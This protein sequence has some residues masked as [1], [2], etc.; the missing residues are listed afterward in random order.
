MVNSLSQLEKNILDCKTAVETYN[1]SL[2][3][4]NWKI[5]ERV[6]TEFGNIDSE[7]GNLAD[8]FDNF[9]DI[10]V[11]DGEG[12]W[13]NQAIATLGLYAQ[14][15][16]LAKYQVGQ[17]GDAIEQ[18]KKDYQAG[19]YSATEYMDKLADLSQE[20]WDAIDSIESME[21]AIIS[22]NETRVNEEIEVINEAI[23]AYKEYTDSQIDA[24]E[25]A[26]DL[27]DYQEE[28]SNKTK[29]VSDIERQLAAMQND[30]SAATIA[31]RKKLEE[32][33]SEA[34]KDLEEAEYDHS[35]ESQKD[36]LN[37]NY[38]DFEE[39][40]NEEIEL[41]RESLENRE[42]LIS[43]SLESVKANANLVG[44]E[45]AN[46]ATQHG[47]IV[48]DAIISSWRTGENAIASYGAVLSQQSSAFIG[49][50]MGVQSYVYG[51]Q[52]QAND[53]ANSLSYMFST[54][55]DNL[56]NQLTSSYYSEANLNS[57]TNT[58]QNS[59]INTLERG[60][61]IDS[62]TNALSSIASGADSVADA[63]GRAARALS[64]MGAISDTGSF[65]DT[66]SSNR[67]VKQYKTIPMTQTGGS[68]SLVDVQTGRAIKTGLSFSEAKKK[69]KASSSRGYE[70]KRMAKGGIVT[71]DDDGIFDPIAKAIGEDTMVAVKH[72]EG[73]FTP[74][75]TK[76]LMALMPTLDNMSK[77]WDMSSLKNGH[78]IP[79]IANV[80]K[81]RPN[82]TLH[83]DSLIKVNGDVNDTNHFLKQVERVSQKCI[84]K[85]FEE[86]GREIRY[87]R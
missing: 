61:N 33:L 59:L 84:N 37:K 42:F 46:I 8:L 3:Q 47:V 82:V 49:N 38:E 6:Q 86:M 74:E 63:A 66:L 58:L 15:L 7:L 44:Q 60:Y 87:G 83:Y 28:I 27:H 51:L 14:Q 13:T 17:Y 12:T 68:Y 62:I 75:Q 35:I 57:M 26:K 79:E 21:D 29:T 55:A 69:Q 71:K 43:D 41:L 19:K 24:L 65:S 80:K 76:T 22:L 31:K 78:G 53:T 73:I 48:S 67:S 36:A 1:N 56:V 2:L 77:T 40:R 10:R 30:D 25:A 9:N 11:S 70:I 39:A 85:T 16:E 81:D 20:Q 64:D 45:I 34:K 4:L 54:R 52:A 18:L 72:G 23:D 32:Q 50:I 5:F